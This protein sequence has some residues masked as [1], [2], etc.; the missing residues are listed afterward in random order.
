MTES[1]LI[2]PTIQLKLV[3]LDVEGIS[4]GCDPFYVIEFLRTTA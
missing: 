1:H 3:T 2:T 4:V